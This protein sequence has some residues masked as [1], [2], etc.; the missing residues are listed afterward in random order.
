VVDSLDRDGLLPAIVF[1]FSRAGCDAAVDQCRYAHVRLT[2]A[3]EQDEIVRLVEDRLD[4]VSDADLDVLGYDGWLESLSRGVAAHHAGLLPVFKECVEALFVRGLVKVVFAT[5]TLALGINMP[6]RS[7]VIEKLTKWNGDAHADIT[8]GEY[9]QLTGRAGRRGIDL[10]GHA[11]VQWRPDVD[12]P[13]V[14]GLASTR[15]YPLRS[16]FRPSYNMA[17]NLVGQVGRAAARTLLESSF[18]Q[19]QSDRAVVG[20]ARQ[21]RRATELADALRSAMSCDRGDAAEYARLRARLAQLEARTKDDRRRQRRDD[22]ATTLS[23][24]R[25]G[26]VIDV[27]R[28]RWAGR[29]VVVD[30]GLAGTE[31]RPVVVTEQRQARRL[32]VADFSGEVLPVA[33]IRVPAAFNPRNPQQRRTLA[34]QLRSRTQDVEVGSRVAVRPSTPDDDEIRRLRAAVRAHPCDRCPDRAE[35]ARAAERLAGAEREAGRLEERIEARTNTLGREF[36]RVCDVLSELGYLAAERLTPAGA[37]LARLYTEL[38]LV[39][40]ECLRRGVWDGLGAPALAACLSAL[41]YEARPT[42]TAAAAPPEDVDVRSALREMTGVGREL[43]ATE[44]SHGVRFVRELDTGFAR[45]AYTWAGGG[46]LASVLLDLDLAP[47]DFVRST[48]QL[49]DL[50]EQVAEAAGESPVRAAARSAVRSLRRG[51]VAESPA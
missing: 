20:L 6:A 48:R 9:T 26:D 51:V 11:V 30:P 18:A 36:D 7:V 31:P 45:A 43:M 33:R 47:G 22:I 15:T 4:D 13:A 5:E 50:C 23:T 38:D 42:E 2:T 32:S 8:P 40:A 44:R 17:V 16:S 19:F 29:A 28:G 21:A 1:I 10:E 27:H 49:I 39:A 34:A 24:L 14:A 37:A 46:D 3:A 25:I 12:I 41:V 35:H